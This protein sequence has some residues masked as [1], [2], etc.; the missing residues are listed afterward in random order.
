MPRHLNTP[1]IS[2]TT[3]AAGLFM[4]V[5]LVAPW[6][7]GGVVYQ[8]RVYLALAVALGFGVIIV[9]PDAPFRV[10]R[11]GLVFLASFGF[12][13]L[14]LVP[15]PAQCVATLSPTAWHWHKMAAEAMGE[16][17]PAWV[18]LTLNAANTRRDLAHWGLSIVFYFAAVQLVREPWKK[19]WVL[20]AI[21]LAGGAYAVF[22]V[23]QQLNWNGYFYW[24]VPVTGGGEPFGAFYSRN[25]GA[26]YLLIPLGCAIG[27]LMPRLAAPAL[28][29][30]WLGEVVALVAICVVIGAAIP[31]SQSRGATLAAAAGLVVLVLVEGWRNR[32]RILP[33]VIATLLILTSVYTISWLGQ[34]EAVRERLATLTSAESVKAEGRLKHWPVAWRTFQD[35]PLVGAGPGTHGYVYRPHVNYDEHAWFVHAENQY[36]ETLVHTGIVGAVFLLA[37]LVLSL[38]NCSRCYRLPGTANQSVAAMSLFI[39]I[40]VATHSMFDFFV[41]APAVLWTFFFLLGVCDCT[42]EKQPADRSASVRPRASWASWV[43]F[44][45]IGMAVWSLFETGQ[46]AQIENARLMSNFQ[47]T[48]D[49][50]ANRYNN[51]QLPRPLEVNALDTAIERLSLAVNR[52]PDDSETLFRLARCQINRY[53]LACAEDLIRESPETTLEQWWPFT[54]TTY[55]HGRLIQ[56][57][58]RRDDESNAQLKELLES[59]PVQKYLIPATDNLRRA[60]RANPLHARTA[61]Y[62][63]ELAPLS[64]SGSTMSDERLIRLVALLSPWNESMQYRCGLL[65]IQAGRV[66]IGLRYWRRS[67]EI[68]PRY[69]GTTL[70][71]VETVSANDYSLYGQLLPDFP[72]MKLTVAKRPKTP[73]DVKSRLLSQSRQ[74]LVEQHSRTPEDSAL[75]AEICF[76]QHDL[77]SAIS[78]LQQAVEDRPEEFRWRRQLAKHLM[79][80]NRNEEAITQVRAGLTTSPFDGPLRQ[81][82]KKLGITSISE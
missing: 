37:M 49:P 53:Q 21:A 55:L 68:S 73:S 64:F 46:R 26:G 54:T 32:G 28:L 48:P 59:P 25:Q 23:V 74:Q 10:P 22:A 51:P 80:T 67:L 2:A 27:L 50:Q 61:A 78:F 7:F 40:A 77:V 11:L 35:Y 41:Y 36:L 79:A 82:A 18:S 70:A 42:L 58:E 15:L 72:S 1:R 12:G 34:T 5:L 24:R 62:L 43:G 69:L 17:A 75:L 44:A 76:A 56:L 60:A 31:I 65:E 38:L 29:R 33:I 30:R 20:W 66:G 8:L 52:V 4:G 6:L 3:V 45:L 9:A 63:A 81:L 19:E 71:W 47:L 39:W 13:L 16:P 14:M 57:R